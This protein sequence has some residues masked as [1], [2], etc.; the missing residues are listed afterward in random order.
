MTIDEALV[1]F[2]S[3]YQMAKKLNLE[4]VNFYTWKRKNFIPLKQQFLINRLLGLNLPIDYDKEAMQ[5]RIG[6]N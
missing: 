2:K 6:M 1:H 5:A 3:G 4:P